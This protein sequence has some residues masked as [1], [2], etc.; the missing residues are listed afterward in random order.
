MLGERGGKER[1]C[2]TWRPAS[3]PPGASGQVAAPVM[4][5]RGSVAVAGRLIVL[6]RRGAGQRQRQRRQ[7]VQQTGPHPV[8]VIRHDCGRKGA[9]QAQ[10]RIREGGWRWSSLSRCEH[11]GLA[12]PVAAV[13][14]DAV[15]DPVAER[16][17]TIL[18]GS[19]RAPPNRRRKANSS[20]IACTLRRNSRRGGTDR[21]RPCE[22]EMAVEHAPER[23]LGTGHGDP[24]LPGR[25]ASGRRRRSSRGRRCRRTRTRAWNRRRRPGRPPLA[26]GNIR[27]IEISR[28]VPSIAIFEWPR[29]T[30]GAAR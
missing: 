13:G 10:G 29:E 20:G 1:S 2:S 8:P 14:G 11:F 3:A 24:A 17:W 30:A 7:K 15:V 16:R 22:A 27:G 21:C 12:E 5:G 9:S 19:R 6:E 23:R 18:P 4:R 25:G 26:P 28:P